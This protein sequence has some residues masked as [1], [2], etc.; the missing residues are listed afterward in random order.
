MSTACWTFSVGAFAHFID[1][2]DTAEG[3]GRFGPLV[4][5]FFSGCVP[6]LLAMDVAGASSDCDLIVASLNAKRVSLIAES[7]DKIRRLE[8]ALDRLNAKQGL[9]FVVA[10]R[11]LDK[12]TLRTI[13]VGMAG[14]IGTVGPVVLAL[15]P[16]T[17]ASGDAAACAPSETEAAVIRSLLGGAGACGYDNVTIGSILAG[18]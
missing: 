2:L 4:L 15:R 6:L 16:E 17:H 9:G 14:F 5:C 11:V 10:G 3:P 13:F 1:T 7:D 12:K 8:T 18:N